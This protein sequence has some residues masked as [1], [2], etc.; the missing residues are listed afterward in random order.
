MNR[1]IITYNCKALTDIWTGSVDGIETIDPQQAAGILRHRH[2]ER[3][4]RR[5][6][7]PPVDCGFALKLVFATPLKGPICIGYGSHFGLG[8]FGNVD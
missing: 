5:G 4:R 8:L 1:Q 3:T 2:F 6:P 7:A